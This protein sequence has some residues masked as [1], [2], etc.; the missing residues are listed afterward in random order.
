LKVGVGA[1]VGM[2]FEAIIIDRGG[3]HS[4][5][6]SGGPSWRGSMRD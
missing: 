3:A 5:P 2:R 6:A 4:R 1:P